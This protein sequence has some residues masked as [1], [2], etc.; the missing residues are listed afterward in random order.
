MLTACAPR[1]QG[2]PP[3][4]NRRGTAAFTLAILLCASTAHATDLGTL[5]GFDLRWDTTLRDSL[6]WRIDQSN[7]KLLAN[8]NA[9]DGDRAFSPGLNTA[10]LDLF[11]EITAQR[12]DLG[13]DISA[14]GWYDPIYH[15]STADRSPA[16]FNADT[17]PYNQFTKATQQLM[18]SDAE[19]VNAYVKD[20]FTVN[21]IPVSLHLG[22]QTL[23]WGESL[24]FTDNGIA[25]GQAPVDSIKALS[26]PLA[27]ARE[28]YMPVAQAVVHIELS[29]SIAIE[30][31]DQFEWRRDRL[32]AVG[33]YFSTTDILDTGGEQVLLSNGNSLYRANDSKP[34]GFGQFGAA[35]K[36]QSDNF[37]YGFY[38][39]RYDAKLPE[40]IFTPATSSYHLVFPR[41]I[42]TLGASASIYLGDNN[43]A[44]EVSF[45]HNMPLAAGNAG[46]ASLNS[47]GSPVYAFAYAA[48]L[49]YPGPPPPPPAYQSPTSG[50]GSNAVGNTAHAQ[51]SLN[52]QF[53]PSNFWQAATLQA[54]IA[55]NDLLDVT[56]GRQYV[57]TGRTH[58]AASA[59][60]VFTPSYFQVLPGLDLGLP[61]GMGYTPIGRSSIDASQNSGTGDA[62]ISVSATYHTVW[63]GLASFTH[64]I[65]GASQQKL[66]DRDFAILSVTRS[67]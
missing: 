26:A 39:L 42:E 47:G 49:D 2:T 55:A 60:I 44:G 43:L 65:G 18:G 11:T 48:A 62:T 57:E 4:L 63:Q 35:L 40:P 45:R 53:A 20:N 5:D 54:E 9:D 64:F 19:L 15:Q 61:I 1:A 38:A 56:H 41:N 22:R 27:Q 58:F 46:L 17:V 10:R 34:H 3:P 50:D 52:S 31:Y 36:L 21:G 33:S 59:R 37:D 16:T 14:Q 8:I 32:P 25:A 7:P 29:P 66:A 67:F 6:G 30:A 13:F 12:G 28:L 51:A 23:L 24:F